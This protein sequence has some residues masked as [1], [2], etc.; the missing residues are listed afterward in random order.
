MEP[1][2]C[3]PGT[4][5][6][7]GG[8][9]AT[10]IQPGSVACQGSSPFYEGGCD[11]PISFA[12]SQPTDVD[13]CCNQ[14]REMEDIAEDEFECYWKVQWDKNDWE[15]VWGTTNSCAGVSWDS[16][17]AYA[18]RS[19]RVKVGVNDTSGTGAATG[20]DQVQY[21]LAYFS[22]TPPKVTDWDFN[23]ALGSYDVDT[24]TDGDVTAYYVWSSTCTCGDPAD[25]DDVWIREYVTWDGTDNPHDC[26]HP[27]GDPPS[28][29]NCFQMTQ[30]NPIILGLP[31]TSGQAE[32]FLGA[33]DQYYTPYWASACKD[34]QKIQQC[35]KY[36]DSLPISQ[37]NWQAADYENDSH[38]WELI[39][40]HDQWMYVENVG[41]W[42]YRFTSW[43][44]VHTKGLPYN[45]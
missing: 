21:C 7:H 2:T 27:V 5:A 45:P 25:L 35:V 17:H 14:D 10:P 11:S 30:D 13:H 19:Y 43:G 16:N 39:R 29:T 24:P 42:R 44:I 1:G 26:R 28:Y 18:P 22:L 4:K 8:C 9:A 33:P 12:K 23:V 36:K 15:D 37:Y 3:I 34:H 38:P 31:A 40:E 6:E 41:G 20:D 32:D